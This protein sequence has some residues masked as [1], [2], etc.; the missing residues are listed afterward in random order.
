M[1]DKVNFGKCLEMLL[2][3]RGWSAARLAREINVDASYTRKWIRGT[4]VPSLQIG[5]LLF[6]MRCLLR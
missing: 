5:T 2:C 3:V 4:R 6:H 1:G